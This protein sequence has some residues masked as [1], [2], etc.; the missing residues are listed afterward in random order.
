MAAVFTCCCCCRGFPRPA[1]RRS[2]TA[3][4]DAVGCCL[5]PR[6]W[7]L[8]RGHVAD[9]GPG[10][11]S[12]AA[13]GFGGGVD[14]VAVGAVLLVA[15]RGCLAAGRYGGMLA[16]AGQ[17]NWRGYVRV[18]PVLPANGVDRRVDGGDAA[19]RNDVDRRGGCCES[20]KESVGAHGTS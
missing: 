13:L 8:P 14:V 2:T 5:Q 19:G 6:G 17:T 20:G 15:E 7:R 18:F 12:P 16:A 1:I 4:A 3:A 9:S 11:D 10:R